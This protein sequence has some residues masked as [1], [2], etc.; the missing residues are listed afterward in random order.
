MSSVIGK[1]GLRGSLRTV[2][3]PGVCPIAWKRATRRASAPASLPLAAAPVKLDDVYRREFLEEL[4]NQF[5]EVGRLKRLRHEKVG[6]FR[7]KIGDGG[8][9]ISTE[10]DGTQFW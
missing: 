10:E 3:V 5:C 9:D 2:M 7:V 6:L 8:G 1:S 4:F